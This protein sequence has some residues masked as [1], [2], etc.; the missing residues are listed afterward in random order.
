M[1]AVVRQA[2]RRHLRHGVLNLSLLLGCAGILGRAVQLQFVE[3]IEWRGRAIA[4]HEKRTPLP[5]PR[6]TIYDREGREL[7]VSRTKYKIAVAPPE[8]LDRE[9]AAAALSLGMRL[10][11]SWA[12]RVRAA[13]KRWVQLPGTHSAAVKEELEA[14]IGA[15]I[16]ATPVVERFYPLGDLAAEILGRVD[17]AGR[18]GGGLELSFDSLL[19][20]QAGFGIERRDA[21]GASA[22]WLTTPVVSPSPGTDIVLTIDAE[23]Q[24]LAESVLEDAIVETD[25]QGGDLLIL[26]PKTGDLLAVVSRRSDGGIPHL[27]AATEP[28][29]PGSTL[30]PFT[31]AALLAEDLAELTDSVDTGLGTYTTAGR[32]IHDEHPHG[33]LS[34]GQVLQV[35]SNVGMAKFAER[36]PEGVQFS[37]LRNF[38]FGTPTGLTYPS[39]SS[40]RLRK[41]SQWSAQ[42]RASL[43]IGYEVAVTPLQLAMAYGALANGGHLMRPRLVLEARS[44]EARTRWRSEPEAIR[45]VVP[46]DVASELRT[47][48]ANVVTQ[49]TGRGAGVRGLKVG[50]KTGTAKRFHADLGYSRRVYTASFVGLI[51]SDDPQLVL[52]VKLDAPSGPYYGGG[53]TAAPVMRTAVRAALAGSHWSVPPLLGE[54]DFP[55]KQA[56]V[57]AGRASAGGPYVFAVGEPLLRSA[58][59]AGGSHQSVVTLP[60]VTGLSVRAAVQRLHQEGW[61]VEVTGG[62]RVESMHPSAGSPLQRGER[63]SLVGAAVRSPPGYAGSQSGSG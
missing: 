36:L 49:G 9:S 22:G 47:V 54:P 34:L 41:P 18:G 45:R 11:R 25:A 62:G 7:A 55:D 27:T 32:T 39:E 4:Q 10:D 59:G 52:L 12:H 30:K 38:G 16:Y 63:V 44:A 56:G 29:E 13:D 43:A 1:R 42:S 8:L 5:A 57:S 23:L 20:G 35:S 3:R 21:T 53:A 14:A 61:R 58:S 50:G 31:T 26:D 17:H 33:E 19:T 60:D 37:Y 6:G 15:G 40:G 51:P 2:R 28:Y 24:A 46:E 48:L